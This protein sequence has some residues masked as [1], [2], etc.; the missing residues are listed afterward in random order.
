MNRMKKTTKRSSTHPA[1][2]PADERERIITTFDRV[3]KSKAARSMA[4]LHTRARTLLLQRNGNAG[5]LRTEIEELLHELEVYQVEL[6]IQQEEL[7]ESQR[8]LEE[9][10]RRYYALYHDAPVGYVTLSKDGRI[11]EANRAAERL[12]SGLRR[13]LNGSFFLQFLPREYHTDFL[14]KV[15]RLYAG[16]PTETCETVLDPA[17]GQRRYLLLHMNTVA[18]HPSE[19][20]NH[21]IVIEDISARKEAERLYTA[22]QARLEEEVERKTKKVSA[23]NRTLQREAQKRKELIRVLQE[24]EHKYRSLFESSAA[25][26]LITDH[27]GRCL[28]ANRPAVKALGRA[29]RLLKNLTLMDLAVEEDRETVGEFWRGFPHRKN[30]EVMFRAAVGRRAETVFECRAVA[31]VLPG[32]H[33]VILHDVSERTRLEHELDAERT[34]LNA[35]IRGTNVGTW[36]WHIPTGRTIFNERWAEMLGYSLSEFPELSIDLWKRLTHP[37]DLVRSTRL[38][39]EHFAGRS[40]YY[41]ADIRMRHKAGHW[42]WILDIGRVTTRNADG[43][44]LVMHGFHQDIS[45]RKKNEEGIRRSNADLEERVRQR[46]A[47]LQKAYDE[48][49]SF[50]YSVSHDLRAP[51]RA[52]DGFSV[53]LQ[54]H[55][56]RYNDDETHRLLSVIRRSTS[57]MDQLI[58]GLLSI[59]RIGT[60]EMRPQIIDM[61]EM[62]HAVIIE[63]VPEAVRTRIRLVVSPV[64]PVKT[65]AVLLRQVWTNLISNAVKYSSHQRNP[66]IEIFSKQ[67]PADVTYYVRDNGVGFKQEHAGI[68]FALFHRLHTAEEFE[69]IGIGLSTVKRIITRLGGSI[70]AEGEVGKGATFWFTLPR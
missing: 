61:E 64:P 11:L 43:S 57:R 7:V 40:E 33:L 36:E 24:S 1:P 28:D 39:E 60:Q 6:E 27:D 4:E 52:I 66:S 12:F 47:S 42:V 13:P 49:E 53:M 54:E 69:G 67:T 46:T 50:S 38:L 21:R 32:M 9:T 20:L 18:G 26:F 14:S 63:T 19:G 59:T 55:L 56:Q 3:R 2:P 58:N 68:L 44:P 48:L 30:A 15:R 62:V 35:V 23:Q 51:I 10:S 17:D 31:D 65:D 16:A 29:K 25:C 5:P 34:R 8:K 45:E 37:E 41:E 70:G 22:Y